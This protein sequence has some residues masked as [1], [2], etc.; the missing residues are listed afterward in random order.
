M[1]YD[2]FEQRGYNHGD[3]QS[4]WYEAEKIILKNNKA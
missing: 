3:D 2:L 1:A 4:D